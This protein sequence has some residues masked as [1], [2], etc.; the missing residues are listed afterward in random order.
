ML[1]DLVDSALVTE[2]FWE[3]QRGDLV[4]QGVSLGLNLW[5]QNV[6]PSQVSLSL[7]LVVETWTLSYFSSTMLT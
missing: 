2:H 5:F 3:G 1:I 6:M 4:G 7:K